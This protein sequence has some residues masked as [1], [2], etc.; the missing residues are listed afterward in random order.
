MTNASAAPVGFGSPARLLGNDYFGPPQS[1]YHSNSGT[2]GIN[3]I[4][5][6]V[7][8]EGLFHKQR[9]ERQHLTTEHN[10][11]DEGGVLDSSAHYQSFDRR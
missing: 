8:E 1:Q 9:F 11:S 4:G 7:V 2:E 6:N 5:K 3:F 10:S